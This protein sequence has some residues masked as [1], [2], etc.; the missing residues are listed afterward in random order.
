MSY[1]LDNL[2]GLFKELGYYT[3][4]CPD[5][6]GFNL[7]NEQ[8]VI[9]FISELDLLKASQKSSVGET[10]NYLIDVIDGTLYKEKFKKKI[11]DIINE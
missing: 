1:S 2:T 11:E 9:F 10:V 4:R 8:G 3:Y 6:N 5:H 7:I